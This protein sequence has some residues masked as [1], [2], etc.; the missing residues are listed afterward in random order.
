VLTARAS[1]LPEVVG[2]AGVYFD[3]LSISEFA[4]A[5]AEIADPRKLRD[6][7][8]A[9]RRRSGEFNW[10]RMADPVVAWAKG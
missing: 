1:S 9:A 10:R 7:A 2:D 4:A 8:P 3:P 6:L 5:L